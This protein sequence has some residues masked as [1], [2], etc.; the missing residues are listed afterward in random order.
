MIR[1]SSNSSSISVRKHAFLLR[2]NGAGSMGRWLVAAR[3]KILW[4]M[5]TC[6]SQDTSSF[7]NRC[8]PRNLRLPSQ[9]RSS[10]LPYL[11]SHLLPLRPPRGMLHP[12]PR[13]PG[14]LD[15]S[16]ESAFPSNRMGDP[17]VSR[18]QRVGRNLAMTLVTTVCRTFCKKS[19]QC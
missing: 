2:E 14:K 12:P 17:A 10:T 5:K 1:H 18:R 11:Q 4:P 3:L 7:L 16:R 19:C 6:W 15:A 13:R 9:S 8:A